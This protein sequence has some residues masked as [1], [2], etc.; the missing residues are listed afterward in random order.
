MIL[1]KS[2]LSE[3]LKFLKSIGNVT[4]GQDD[5]GVLLKNGFL[6]ANNL[7]TSVVVP[8]KNSD[9]NEEILIPT[10]AIDF[11]ANLSD[12]NV[13]IKYKNN[14]INVIQ[15][16]VKCKFS[17]RNPQEYPETDM[18]A[19]EIKSLLFTIKARELENI[20][21][22][23]WFACS[24]KSETKPVME[25]ILFEGDNSKL[26]IVASDGYR[27]AWKQID[28]DTNISFKVAIEKEAIQKVLSIADADIAIYQKSKKSICFVAGEYQIESV[29]LM[30]EQFID[31]KNLFPTRYS[32]EFNVNRDQLLY[33]F[34]RM[35]VSI[36]NKKRTPAVLEHSENN[37]L[38]ISC[39]DNTADISE[40]I[41][42][43]KDEFKEPLKI[44]VNIDYLKDALKASDQEVLTI[45]ATG[46]VNPIIL[47]DGS[48]Q[49]LVLPVRLKREVLV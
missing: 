17:T 48:L 29:L 3:K 32:T 10:R 35:S 8:L 15:G 42:L 23:V 22:Q 41:V 11:I 49:Q 28:I 24:K 1:Q 39:A 40:N 6:I 45:R 34:N 31:Y 38:S 18:D 43:A 12:G 13:E 7:K 37:I 20:V 21:K 16:K 36:E 47:N 33:C 4:L 44:G 27:L 46:S 26:S 9:K 2:E 14:Q 5:Q 30:A 25:G 19:P